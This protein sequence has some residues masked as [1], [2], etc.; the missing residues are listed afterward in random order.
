M[1]YLLFNPLADGGNGEAA[2]VEVFDKLK[3][4]Y[5][6]LVKNSVLNI[7]AKEFVKSLKKDDGVILFGGDGTLNHFIN[8]I[9][10]DEELPCPFYL[11]PSG[12]GND[13]LNDVMKQKDEKTGL[14][15]LNEFVKGL[16]YVEVKG[17]TYRFINGIGYGIDGECCVEAEKMK[18]AGE[19][20]IDYSKITI[21]LLMKSYVAPQAVVKVDGKEFSFK[22]VYL[23]SAMN[24][25]YYGGGMMIAPTQERGSG[26][27][28]FVAIHGRGK[29]GT[30]L[31][32]PSIFKGKHINKKKAVSL[33]LGKVIEVSFDK[34]TGLQI[35]GEVVEGVTSYKAYIN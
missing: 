9:D 19:K 33:V 22:K 25:R 34:P 20:K 21:S 29:L 15:L 2:S 28:S 31:L 7:K 30:L 14:V 23:A 18:K 6:G 3:E 24:G 12:T 1:Y 5:P 10:I 16:P 32:F 27:L 35:D 26:L 17:K 8:A 11:C 4:F 13:F